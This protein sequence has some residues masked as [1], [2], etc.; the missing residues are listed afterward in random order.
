MLSPP[1]AQSW[2]LGSTLEAQQ[3]CLPSSLVLQHLHC[4]TSWQMLYQVRAISDCLISSVIRYWWCSKI[5]FSLRCSWTPG[6]LA[7]ILTRS[8]VLGIELLENGLYLCCHQQCPA[9]ALAGCWAQHI[10]LTA[11]LRAVPAPLPACGCCRLQTHLWLSFQ[12]LS[13][14]CLE[15]SLVGRMVALSVS[16]LCDIV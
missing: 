9:G 5:A 16:L 3:S 10:A 6:K 4:C 15:S 12:G 1:L 13:Q 8:V 11:V 7:V 2:A 14:T